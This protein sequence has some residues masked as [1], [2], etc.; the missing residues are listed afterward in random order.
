MNLTRI[1]RV[2]ASAFLLWMG[3]ASAQP[4]AFSLLSPSSNDTIR[5]KT[6]YYYC[7]SSSG[8]DHYELWV[9]NAK[10]E[11]ATAN[12]KTPTQVCFDSVALTPGQHSWY[13]NA[14]NASG[15]TTKSSA[16]YQFTLLSHPD[17]PYW[18]IGP[19]QKYGANPILV[20]QGTGTGFESK[21][22]LNP[23]VIV[24]DTGCFQMVY[25]AQD[26]TN[27]YSQI[28]YAHGMDGV[29]F[30]RYSGNPVIKNNGTGEAYG[31]EDPRLVKLGN[32]YYCYYAS[33]DGS[34]AICVATS[35]DMINWTKYGPKITGTKNACILVNSDGTP[36]KINNKYYMYHGDQSF[37]NNTMHVVSSTDLITWTEVGVVDLRLGTNQWEPCVAIAD[38]SP[39][40]DDIVVLFAGKLWGDVWFTPSNPLWY[41]YAISEVLFTKSN[42]LE[43]IDKLDGMIILP[44]KT[45]ETNGQFNNCIFTN[46]VLRHGNVWWNHY[47]AGDSRVAVALAPERNISLGPNLA[48]GKTITASSSV[49]AAANA[50]DSSCATRWESSASDSQWI[51]VDLG[52]SYNVR[53]VIL[54]WEVAYGKSYRIQVSGNASSWTD[55]Y[56]TTTGTGDVDD[57]VLQTPL[58]G[59][60]VRMLGSQRGTT[61]GYS[62]WEFEIYGTAAVNSAVRAMNPPSDNSLHVNAT[63]ITFSLAMA[64]TVTLAV[65]SAQG[66][67]VVRT[68]R[69]AREGMNRIAGWSMFNSL[70]AGMY[71]MVLSLQDKESI[72]ARIVKNNRLITQY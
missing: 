39:N 36:A 18:A 72:I 33:Y 13:F 48:K 32:T 2:T 38:A 50:V 37:T 1:I 64:Q 60:Y 8:A 7:Q 3:I 55:A 70:P 15:Q 29:T 35:T 68:T 25:R 41:Y 16:T 22:V 61:F 53:R 62:L 71:C 58:Q 42:M 56:L 52:T 17:L 30:T 47:G 59:R 44:N 10:R 40:T 27:N 43:R 63:A 28:G 21:N 11:E 31:C 4:A 51:M 9:D 14:V 24:D 67:M 20:P 69:V 5:S 54:K 34:V 46:S 57:I 6:V 12:V 45:Y 19:F 26:L 65:Y 23:G 49:Q 66:K